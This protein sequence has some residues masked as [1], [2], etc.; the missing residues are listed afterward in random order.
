MVFIDEERMERREGGREGME[1]REEHIHT[2]IP[3][4][5]QDRAES[6][7]LRLSFSFTPHGFFSLLFFP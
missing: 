3:F 1:E 7:P 5:D 2:R 6:N 4:K